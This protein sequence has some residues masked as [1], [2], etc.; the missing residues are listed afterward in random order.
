MPCSVAPDS[1]STI[2][3][4]FGFHLNG[5]AL[6]ATWGAWGGEG[7]DRRDLTG[8]HLDWGGGTACCSQLHDLPA[9]GSPERRNGFGRERSPVVLASEIECCGGARR[10]D[11][12]KILVF[13]GEGWVRDFPV[14]DVGN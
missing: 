3:V 14:A 4:E 2:S 7:L 10:G 12:S 13:Q 8:D 9:G 5:T 11:L 6:A 1:R